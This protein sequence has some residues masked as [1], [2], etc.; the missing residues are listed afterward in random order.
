MSVPCSD[1]AIFFK[2]SKV[3]ILPNVLVI[4]IDCFLLK[5]GLSEKNELKIL[6][7]QSHTIFY[8]SIST[9]SLG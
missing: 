6:R 4:F 2:R 9:Y 3:Q 8:F 7:D 1:I 5:N